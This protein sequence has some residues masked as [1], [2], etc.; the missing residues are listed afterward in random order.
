[1]WFP[2]IAITFLFIYFSPI[3]A[4]GSTNGYIINLSKK[5]IFIC[6]PLTITIKEEAFDFEMFPYRIKVSH[7]HEGEVF[8][9]S[10]YKYVLKSTGEGWA[11]ID[12]DLWVDYDTIKYIFSKP[13]KYLLSISD[14]NHK[15]LFTTEVNVLNSN[16]EDVE[17][18]K[19]INNP[20]AFKVL[21]SGEYNQSGIK[22]LQKLN[23]KYPD[24]PWS[25]LIDLQVGAAMFEHIKRK[26]VTQKLDFDRKIQDIAKLVKYFDYIKEDDAGYF[27]TKARFYKAYCYAYTGNYSKSKDILNQFADLKVKEY[28]VLADKLLEE[29]NAM[30]KAE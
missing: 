12:I 15:E 5:E 2:R 17:V 21:I 23:E 1:M 20:Y 14:S 26:P 24:N 6:Q 25:K 18:W 19:G 9:G 29:I 8:S 3:D 16:A 28:D 30:E 13:G 22:T 27:F 11:K 7:E 10:Q 4:S